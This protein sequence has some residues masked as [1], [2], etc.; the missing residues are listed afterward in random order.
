V[1]WKP[2]RR[3]AS[4]IQFSQLGSAATTA[5]HGTGIQLSGRRLRIAA[6][7][8]FRAHQPDLASMQLRQ[9]PLSACSRAASSAAC[10]IL[11]R[12]VVLGAWSWRHGEMHLALCAAVCRTTGQCDT[13][14]VVLA[15]RQA[16]ACFIGTAAQR[17]RLHRL[18]PMRLHAWT[19]CMDS[20]C[21]YSSYCC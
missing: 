16:S 5:W 2:R 17:M 21:R 18:M 13:I 10:M 7:V 3:N 15:C 14:A 1:V 20:S 19:A 8:V 9:I 12:L 11:K 4:T 6:S